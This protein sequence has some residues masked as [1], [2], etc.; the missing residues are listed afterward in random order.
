MCLLLLFCCVLVLDVVDGVAVVVV[1]VLLLAC[2]LRVV[3][4]VV[5]LLWLCC[6]WV[7]V[8]LVLLGWGGLRWGGLCCAA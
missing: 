5:V 3:V 8:G 6:C 2:S 4:G 7:V 1:G